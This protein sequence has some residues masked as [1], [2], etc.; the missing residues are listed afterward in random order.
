M[1]WIG[2]AFSSN[3]HIYNYMKLVSTVQSELY[4]KLE[5]LFR[6]F[7]G[8]ATWN[9]TGPVCGILELIPPKSTSKLKNTYSERGWDEWI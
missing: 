5:K 3:I 4:S 6:T 2:Y 9:R 8:R 7:L 1:D